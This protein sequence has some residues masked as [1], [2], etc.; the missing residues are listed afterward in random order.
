MSRN[1][2]LRSDLGRDDGVAP[3]CEIMVHRDGAT[4][5][6]RRRAVLRKI[7]NAASDSH[8]NNGFRRSRIVPLLIAEVADVLWAKIID[9][10]GHRMDSGPFPDFCDVVKGQVP[11]PSWTKVRRWRW[12]CELTTRARFWLRGGSRHV[13]FIAAIGHQ[14]GYS[15]DQCQRRNPSDNRPHP[16]RR[17]CG[18]IDHLGYDDRRYHA[19]CGRA[20]LW[21]RLCLSL[22]ERLA[23]RA[24]TSRSEKSVGNLHGRAA[25]RA[26]NTVRCVHYQ[27]FAVGAA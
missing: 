10:H 15:K 7:F 1:D 17:S 24:P 3:V 26:L 13:R 6:G 19:L 9:H 2:L 21:H 11:E 25:L 18:A 23:F 8:A 20:H 4:V 5:A 12:L 27:P 22:E 16:S 14:E